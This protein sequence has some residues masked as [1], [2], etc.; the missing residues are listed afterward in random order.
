MP[1]PPQADPHTQ[2][3]LSPDT[4]DHYSSSL[5]DFFPEQHMYAYRNGSR[6]S[7]NI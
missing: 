3:E 5:W 6:F 2:A 1:T 4:C 7:Q